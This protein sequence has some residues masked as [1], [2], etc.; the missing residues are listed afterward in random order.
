M[1]P[2]QN[3]CGGALMCYLI[4]TLGNDPILI[5]SFVCHPTLCAAPST[6]P[7]CLRIYTEQYVPF[8]GHHVE[9]FWQAR[10]E[11]ADMKAHAF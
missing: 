4:Y 3:Q 6:R 5:V 1:R 10:G 7:I 2:P 9:H 11:K 8:V